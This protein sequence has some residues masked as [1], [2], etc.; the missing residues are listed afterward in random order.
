M[1]IDKNKRGLDN[2][3]ENIKESE[4]NS[5]LKDKNLEKIISSLESRVLKLENSEENKKELDGL[6]NSYKDLIL[7]VE[8]YELNS[9]L[10]VNSMKKSLCRK[11]E[12]S[13]LQEKHVSFN[14]ELKTLTM[15]V[16]QIDLQVEK[17]KQFALNLQRSEKATQQKC[18]EHESILLDLQQKMCQI[19]TK[20]EDM[21]NFDYLTNTMQ[22]NLENKFTRLELR[23]WDAIEA[24]IKNDSKIHPLRTLN[25]KV[26][27]LDEKLNSMFES[28]NE[29]SKEILRLQSYKYSEH[30]EKIDKQISQSPSKKIVIPYKDKRILRSACNNDNF[31]NS[32]FK[33]TY[34]GQRPSS[35]IRPSSSINISE[36]DGSYRTLYDKLAQTDT[37]SMKKFKD[38][39]EIEYL[40]E[41]NSNDKQENHK[42]FADIRGY[43]P[44]EAESIVMSAII[45]KANKS[46]VP[47]MKKSYS[48]MNLSPATQPAPKTQTQFPSFIEDISPSIELHE[49][50]KL[51]GI[52]I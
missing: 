1:I 19:N 22:N 33:S 16:N 52:I 34:S 49:S 32:V 20:Y 21:P 27:T 50:L 5:A 45:E 10:Q 6:R 43:L 31:R 11:Q 46:R 40:Q 51:R 42:T 13:I 44:G 17:L 41:K 2:V 3:V 15:V 18:E 9:K 28:I 29:N 38:E 23:V 4:K 47:Q 24:D 26:H 36:Q 25:M 39:D 12:M 30:F 14:G 37:F 48:A 7:R 8:K 35:C